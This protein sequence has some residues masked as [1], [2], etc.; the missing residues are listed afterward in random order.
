MKPQKLESTLVKKID[1]KW[2]KKIKLKP[3]SWYHI[4]SITG[5]WIVTKCKVKKQ[6]MSN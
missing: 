6:K 2:V 4:F 5:R 1:N 3:N